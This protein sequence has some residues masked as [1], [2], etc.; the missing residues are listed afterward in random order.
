MW[1]NTQQNGNPQSPPPDYIENAPRPRVKKPSV[2]LRQRPLV[3]YALLAIT[4]LV[5]LLQYASQSFFGVDVPAALGAKVNILIYQGEIWRLITP[6]FLHGSIL[7]LGFN[8]YALYIFGPGLERYYR[9]WRFLAL[10]LLAGFGGNVFSFLFTNA[11]SL[12]SSTAIFGLLAAEGVFL[13]QNRKLFGNVAQRALMNI[14][15]IAGINL[16]IGLSPG[17][18]NW[19]HIGGMLA[20]ILFAWYA[21]PALEVSGVYPTFIVEDSRK[22]KDTWKAGISVLIFFSLL[23]AVSFY[24]Y[25]V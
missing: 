21:G 14:V 7:H 15:V 12:G 20:G 4:I 13:Y 25:Y 5:Y 9:H 1:N 10:Y 16:F 19:G 24:L 8:M 6:V 11:P 22:K 2:P 23:A 3:T 18:D 17:I